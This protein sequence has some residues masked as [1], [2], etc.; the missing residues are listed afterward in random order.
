MR[1]VGRRWISEDFLGLQIDAKQDSISK[2]VAA[3]I[4]ITLAKL[5]GKLPKAQ[6]EL[7]EDSF[8]VGDRD[9]DLLV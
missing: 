2:D 8:L 4:A 9:L 1:S 5:G 6:F 3:S 7:R